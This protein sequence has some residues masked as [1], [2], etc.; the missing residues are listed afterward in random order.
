MNEGILL[1]FIFVANFIVIGF[2]PSS[3]WFAAL[4]RL[5]S[6][7]RNSF[8]RLFLVSVSGIIGFLGMLFVG[9]LIF[10]EFLLLEGYI[11]MI[12]AVWFILTYSQFNIEV[13][14]RLLEKNRRVFS[15]IFQLVPT[16]IGLLIIFL[17]FQYQDFSE[18]FIF[19]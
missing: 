14:Y 8:L 10:P 19:L 9:R 6:R 7:I 12:Y 18:S 15:V 13:V 2:F 16:I 17:S 3:L 1:I 5:R 4:I 11:Q